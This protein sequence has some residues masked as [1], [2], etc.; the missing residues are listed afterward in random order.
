MGNWERGEKVPGRA[1]DSTE[2][3][4]T[5]T[6]KSKFIV[7]NNNNNKKKKK[8]SIQ[9]KKKKLKIRII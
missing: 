3:K 2:E 9:K 1:F 8:N 4:I 6:L 5:I 7:A